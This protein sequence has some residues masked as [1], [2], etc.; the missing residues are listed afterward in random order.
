MKSIFDRAKFT[1][2]L[3][4]RQYRGR[5]KTAKSR[6]RKFFTGLEL[7]GFYAWGFRIALVGFLFGASALVILV[8]RAY[9]TLNFA[10]ES[11]W[12]GDSNLTIL[13]AGLDEKEAGYKF[14]DSITIVRISPETGEMGVLGIDPDISFSHDGATLTLRKA[15][16]FEGDGT[17]DLLE[18]GLDQSL[19]IK[20]DKYI[21]LDEKTFLEIDKIFPPVGINYNNEYKE[22][23]FEEIDGVFTAKEGTHKYNGLDLLACLALDEAGTDKKLDTQ[24]AVLDSFLGNFSGFDIVIK[25][26]RNPKRLHSIETDFTRGEFFDLYMFL[27]RGSE[28]RTK[29]SFTKQNSLIVGDAGKNEKQVLWE[30]V[31]QDIQAVFLD[32]RILQEQVRLE[33]L[34]GTDSAGLASRYKKN[35]ENV[36]LRV[37]REDNAIKPASATTLYIG[38]YPEK[39]HTILYIGEY[40]EKEHTIA[41]IKSVFGDKIQ[42]EEGS[43]KYKHIGDMVLILGENLKN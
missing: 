4:K 12:D 43:Y 25:I 34:N 10:K 33:V 13:V 41:F 37:V 40:P 22:D 21:A 7:K 27:R 5:K 16:N 11:S 8:L 35:F 3:R 2:R 26:I 15:Y 38:E 1:R 23:D 6:S 19:A 14:V 24:V 36:G 39:E 29:I 30:R 18:E 32:E 28:I 17:F 42:I 9:F 20:V 31:S